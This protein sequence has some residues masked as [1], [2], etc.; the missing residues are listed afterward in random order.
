MQRR[1][2]RVQQR[3]ITVYDTV[4][5]PAK[6]AW[7]LYEFCNAYVCQSGRAFQPIERIAFYVDREIKC[8]FLRCFT[9]ETIS[10]GAPR[11]RVVCASRTTDSTERSPML[12]KIRLQPGLMGDIKFS[13]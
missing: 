7:S 2:D 8:K 4:V 6:H 1:D 3:P 11:R 12:S 13:Y 10:S 5:V 9:V